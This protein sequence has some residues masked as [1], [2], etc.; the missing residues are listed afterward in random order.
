MWEEN[1]DNL[2]PDEAPQEVVDWYV[3]HKASPPREIVDCYVHTSA[4]PG[5][6][7]AGEAPKKPKRT[8]LWIFLG[9]MAALLV[10]V[11]LGA[12]LYSTSAPAAGDV[13]EMDPEDE[14]PSSIVHIFRSN[15]IRIPRFDPQGTAAPMTLAQKPEETLTAQEVYAKAAPSTVVV[16]TSTDSSA[17]VGTGVI[18]SEDGYVITNAHVI[19][20]GKA[21]YVATYWGEMYDARLVGADQEQDIAVLK[22]LEAEDL[23]AAEFGDS[24][25]CMVG[26]AVYAIGN[27]L[28]LELMGTMTEGILSAVNRTVR[29]DGR[30]V[31][32]LQTTA[33]LNNGNS[34]GP[35]INDSGQVIGITTLKMSNSSLR[36]D[37]ATVEG[38]GFAL[39][40]GEVSYVVNAMLQTGKFEGKPTFGVMVITDG[41]DDDTRVK[42]YEVTPDGACDAAGV[43]AGDVILA[44]DGREIRTTAEM[45]AIRRT[46]L[47]GQ[48]VTLHLQRG[49][50]IMDVDVTLTAGT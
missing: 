18:L 29:N 38:L 12:V 32:A 3:P 39:P 4:L 9:C 45:L 24:D 7:R 34:G 28:G 8:G 50:Q 10:T 19:A 47:P 41:E 40:T 46:C 36:R 33:A 6:L 20:E 22:M 25:N 27:P 14:N 11:A 26:D 30:Y 42:V 35:L 1:K 21:C 49:S 37:E 2:T 31:T 23:P 44:V 15:T 48:T 43:Q 5:A 17:Y 16:L 13:E